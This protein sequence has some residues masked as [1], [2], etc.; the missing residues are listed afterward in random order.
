MLQRKIN[1]AKAFQHPLTYVLY[2]DEKEAV[3][4]FTIDSLTECEYTATYI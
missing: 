2:C 4:V 3:W 1:F